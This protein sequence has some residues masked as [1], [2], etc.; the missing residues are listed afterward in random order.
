LEEM[1]DLQRV[2]RVISLIPNIIPYLRAQHTRPCALH[3]RPFSKI[4]KLIPSNPLI[5]FSNSKA[6]TS[7]NF[8]SLAHGFDG[9]LKIL[10]RGAKIPHRSLIRRIWIGTRASRRA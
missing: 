6:P 10:Y 2:I 8:G 1:D 3:P 7:L 9:L 4:L 5:K